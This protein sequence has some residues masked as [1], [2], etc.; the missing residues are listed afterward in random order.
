MEEDEYFAELLSRHRNLD[1][2]LQI[3]ADVMSWYPRFKVM[4]FPEK[5]LQAK[6]LFERQTMK[7]NAK[8]PLNMKLNDVIRVE[9]NQIILES[10]KFLGNNF[11]EKNCIILSPTSEYAKAVVLHHHDLHHGAHTH[12]IAAVIRQRYYIP[13]VTKLL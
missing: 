6:K 7:K 5:L 3:M 12:S 9:G 11:P 13:R 10:R 2:T 8:M 1:K 4:S